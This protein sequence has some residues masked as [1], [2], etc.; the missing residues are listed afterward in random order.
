VVEDRG[1][2][3]IN[4]HEHLGYMSIEYCWQKNKVI[5]PI[6]NQ[7]NN[8]LNIAFLFLSSSLIA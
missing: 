8:L 7:H 6:L 2:K 5:S 4:E 3:S 1:G